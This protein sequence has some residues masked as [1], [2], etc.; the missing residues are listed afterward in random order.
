MLMGNDKRSI[1]RATH[2]WTFRGKS[3][4]CA[5]V[6]VDYLLRN[7]GKGDEIEIEQSKVDRS[8]FCLDTSMRF[9]KP[10]G[11]VYSR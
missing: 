1:H 7:V 8:D 5:G 11:D 9:Q 6:L 10:S 3:W 4:L 2:Q